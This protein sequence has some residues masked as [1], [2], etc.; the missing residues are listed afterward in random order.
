MGLTEM[1]KLAPVT[2][3]LLLIILVTSLYDFA[4]Q[5][6]ITPRFMFNPYRV[7]Q[8]REYHRVFSSALIHADFFHLLFNLLV[9]FSFAPILELT[10]GSWQ[11]VV[12]FLVAEFVAHLPR[13]VTERH[14][15]GYN[16][17]GASGAVSGLIF[18]FIL[19]YP[20]TQLRVFLAIPMPAWLFAAL[21]L[22]YSHFA[23]RRQFDNVG[24]DAH[25]WG[26]LGGVIA[27]TA[28]EPSV[29]GHFLRQLGF[30]V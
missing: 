11:M 18:A 21:Y 4:T 15:P 23:A 8:H 16:A 26:A 28:L 7:M 19:Y 20:V 1:L 25:F 17:L 2:S 5:R 27:A 3:F 13:L 29:L 30:G 22:L 14:N 6:S 9:F 12:I 10:V 24:H